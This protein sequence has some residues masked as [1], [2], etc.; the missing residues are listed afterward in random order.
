VESKSRFAEKKSWGDERFSDSLEELHYEL[1]IGSDAKGVK[2]HPD[3]PSSVGQAKWEAVQSFGQSCQ[4]TLLEFLKGFAPRVKDKWEAVWSFG[5]S[6]KNA[7]LDSDFLQEYTARVET[8][9][10]FAE[11]KSW[12]DERL[13]DSLEEL[14]DELGIGSAQKEKVMLLLDDS[15]SMLCSPLAEGKSVLERIMPRLERA[16]PTVHLIGGNIWLF[17]PDRRRSS[18][19]I[20]SETDFFTFN[21]VQDKWTGDSF[22]TFLWEYIF[23]AIMANPGSDQEVIIITDGFDNMSNGPFFGRQGFNHMMMQLR[24]E[25]ISLPRIIV[26]LITDN[27]DFDSNFGWADYRNLA[28]ASGGDFFVSSKAGDKE[29]FIRHCLMDHS[30]RLLKAS[31]QMQLYDETTPEEEKFSWFV[32]PA[33]SKSSKSTIVSKRAWGPACKGLRGA[34]MCG[35]QVR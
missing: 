29:A 12:G 14:H 16:A 30:Q 4:N 11:K 3:T 6:C 5:R 2:V 27:S 1:G 18:R 15:G 19:Q 26:Y 28:T 21:D 7:L 25:G 9:L 8:K 33:V 31:A 20:F 10:R 17:P 35:R 24:L 32:L 22:L 34:W 23:N 13:S